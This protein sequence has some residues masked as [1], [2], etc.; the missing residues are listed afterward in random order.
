MAK[1]YSACILCACSVYGYGTL[2]ERIGQEA[3]LEHVH[4]TVTKDAQSTAKT[5]ST[6]KKVKSLI[7]IHPDETVESD[8]IPVPPKSMVELAIRDTDESQ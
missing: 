7:E 2:L 3:L 1:G 5:G 4:V 6:G 8:G